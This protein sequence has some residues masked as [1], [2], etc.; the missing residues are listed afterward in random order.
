MSTKLVDEYIE[1]IAQHDQP[2]IWDRMSSEEREMMHQ[3][4]KALYEQMDAWER[5]DADDRIN[6]CLS[7]RDEVC[8][9]DMSYYEQRKN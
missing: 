4:C 2:W 5:A 1:W 3:E 9:I 6:E 7:G 8:K